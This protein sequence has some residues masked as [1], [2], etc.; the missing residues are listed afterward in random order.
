MRKDRRAG[1]KLGQR[2]NGLLG[3]GG[4]R[5][6][7]VRYVR[8]SSYFL[9]YRSVGVHEGLEAIHDFPS[10]QA[11]CRNL[12]EVAV[13]EREPRRLGVKNDDVFLK[14]AEICRKRPFLQRKI[15]FPNRGG[16]PRHEE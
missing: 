6:V 9:R 15:P 12:D 7:Y 2:E 5:D 3:R 13:F 14:R 8:K 1:N 11:R 4:V 10:A 16:R